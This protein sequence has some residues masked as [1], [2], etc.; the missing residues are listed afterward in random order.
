LLLRHVE[1]LQAA[2]KESKQRTAS[3]MLQMHNQLFDFILQSL[4]GTALAHG[5]AVAAGVPACRRAGA[6][7]PAD[8][9]HLRSLAIED[10]LDLGECKGLFRAAG[11]APST[12]G[13]TP[14]A[15]V[16][17]TGSSTNQAVK[18]V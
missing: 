1:Y 3:H 4:F 12:S 13:G 10:F 15:T 18:F 14:D 17:Q 11:R 7:R 8:I 5:T 9:A 6:S 16:F 2:A